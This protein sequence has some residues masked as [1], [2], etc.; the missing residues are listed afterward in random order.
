MLISKKLFIHYLEN[1]YPNSKEKNIQAVGKRI[2]KLRGKEYPS[3]Q[4]QNIQSVRK[5]NSSCKENHI[6]TARKRISKL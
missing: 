4:E 1:V 3:W 2:S 6:Q 5:E